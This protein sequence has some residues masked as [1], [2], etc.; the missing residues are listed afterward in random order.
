[1]PPF[2]TTRPGHLRVLRGEAPGVIRLPDGRE[3]ARL[4]GFVR[5]I[6]DDSFCGAINLRY[7]PGTEELPAHVSGH[8]G[9]A[10]VPWKRQQGH[11]TRA[12]SLLLPLAHALGRTRLLITCDEDN[13]ASRR[14]IE[15]NGGIPDGAEPHPERPGTARLR[16]WIATG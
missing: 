10:V 9:Y 6:W 11:A 12:L 14:V 1:M 5:W 15:A 13:A 16:F 4:P 7:Q 3:V 2:A 8:V